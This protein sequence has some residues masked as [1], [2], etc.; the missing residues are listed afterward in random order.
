[1]DS[2]NRIKLDPVI[3]KIS[4]TNFCEKMKDSSSKLSSAIYDFYNSLS[5]SWYSTKAVNFSDK[6]ISELNELS[7]TINS[8]YNNS[9][10]SI[11]D[12]YNSLALEEGKKT[13]DFSTN[14]NL[15]FNYP[16]MISEG[17][18]GV[19]GMNIGK[20]KSALSQ[21]ITDFKDAFNSLSFIPSTVVISRDSNGNKNYYFTSVDELKNNVKVIIEKIINEVITSINQEVELLNNANRLAVDDMK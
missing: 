10:D 6:L 11:I 3:T 19:I 4:L 16:S 14:F 8:Y 17:P 21:F 5:A 13:L 18:N 15:S 1:M 2:Q 12:S 7:I 9:V 20:V